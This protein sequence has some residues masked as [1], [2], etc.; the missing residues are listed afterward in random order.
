MAE[1][2]PLDKTRKLSPVKRVDPVFGL[3]LPDD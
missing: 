3:P 1:A 2:I